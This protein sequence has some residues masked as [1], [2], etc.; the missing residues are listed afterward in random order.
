MVDVSE[1][2]EPDVRRSIETAIR[3]A[4]WDSDSLLGGLADRLERVDFFTGVS[5]DLDYTHFGLR[6][7]VHPGP[8]EFEAT[9]IDKR[10]SPESP[11][12]LEFCLAN[13]GE[14]TQEVSSGTIVPF[15]VVRAGRTTDENE[16][17]LW[18][19]YE[20]ARCVEFTTEGIIQCSVGIGPQWN[21]ARCSPDDTT[22]SP[23]TT[24]YPDRTAP[25]GSRNISDHGYD[26]VWRGERGSRQGALLRGRVHGR[27]TVPTLPAV[28]VL[29]APA[30][31]S[32][33][34]SFY[35]V[36]G[37]SAHV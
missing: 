30:P 32:A 26:R 28:T 24:H 36:A 18:R 3:E 17:L 19:D 22:S 33:P 13:T 8:I 25:P 20:E 34:G 14:D 35:A 5:G 16:F 37:L 29:V 6:L 21:L 27:T 4:E 9:V 12:T 11:R 10:V 23:T 31:I 1:I 7:V 2:D 15:G